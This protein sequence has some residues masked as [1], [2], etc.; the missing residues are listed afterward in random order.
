MIY[1]GT[2]KSSKIT[3]DKS[4]QSKEDPPGK[5]SGIQVKA[6]K[7]GFVPLSDKLLYGYINIINRFIVKRG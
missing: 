1:W 3:I 2:G 7:R 6:N 5:P 4:V